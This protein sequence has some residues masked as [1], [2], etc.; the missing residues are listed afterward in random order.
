MIL[1]F[2]D[3]KTTKPIEFKFSMNICTCH[4]NV[5]N[6]KKFHRIQDL[7]GSSTATPLLRCSVSKIG[8]INIL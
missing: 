1:T 4:K 6:K 8:S 5:Y 3:V 2:M 7:L